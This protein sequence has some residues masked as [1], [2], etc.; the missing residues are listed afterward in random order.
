MNPYYCPDMIRSI[1]DEEDEV[2]TE[3]IEYKWYWVDKETHEPNIIS[4][5][6]KDEEELR[7][8]YKDAPEA[9]FNRMWPTKRL[10]K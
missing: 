2:E 8:E 6:Y 7:A 5:W 10:R 4:G 3:V 9:F 1:C